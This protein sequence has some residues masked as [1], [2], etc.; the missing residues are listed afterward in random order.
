MQHSVN[1]V[2]KVEVAIIKMGELKDVQTEN[3]AK[4]LERD[5]KV[6][7]LLDKVDAMSEET[8]TMK[9]EVD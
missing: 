9:Q 5:A 3:L 7:T 2:D 6:D 1:N 4:L 8:K